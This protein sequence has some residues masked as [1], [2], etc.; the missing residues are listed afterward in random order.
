MIVTFIALNRERIA[1]K[2]EE[3]N[4]QYNSMARGSNKIKDDAG[5]Q[6]G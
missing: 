2:C 5:L 6:K 4:K 1:G 3:E